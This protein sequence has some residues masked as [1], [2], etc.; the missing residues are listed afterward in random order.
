MVSF[1][2][3]SR[4]FSLMTEFR[5]NRIPAFGILPIRVGAN[6]RYKLG[7]QRKET[8]YKIAGIDRGRYS[9]HKVNN[10]NDVRKLNTIIK[11]KSNPNTHTHT[12]IHTQTQ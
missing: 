6:P 3:L 10:Q 11:L 7:F 12:H 9:I 5:P 8:K 2:F 1:P 4:N